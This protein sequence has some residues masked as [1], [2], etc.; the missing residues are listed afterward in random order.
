[1]NHIQTLDTI[2]VNIMQQNFILD[3]LEL[4][5]NQ[6][7]ELDPVQA[8]PSYHKDSHG[9]PRYLWLV[10]PQKNG[11][12]VR[13]YIGCKEEKIK[14]ALVRVQAHRDLVNVQR[15]SADIKARLGLVTRY[16]DAALRAVSVE[17]GGGEGR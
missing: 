11:V 7:Q 4:E 3:M 6:L 5:A 12:R 16:L 1:M 2:K 14:A 8:T 9:Q 10:H 13:E 17:G 15:Q